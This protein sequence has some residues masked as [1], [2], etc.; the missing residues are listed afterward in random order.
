MSN[1]H[2]EEDKLKSHL[3]ELIRKHRELDQ[4]IEQ[5]FYNKT[6]TNE[7]RVL[8]THKLWLKDEIHRVQTKLSQ[9]GTHLNGS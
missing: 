2:N 7:V 9:L 5:E 3:E 8:K 1:Y 4:H 6:I